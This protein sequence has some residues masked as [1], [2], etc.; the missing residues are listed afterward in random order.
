M[1]VLGSL[2]PKRV[3]KYFE[4]I[5]AIPRGSGNMEG[6]AEYCINFAKKHSLKAVKDNANNVI[7]YK[8]ASEGYENADPV[9]LQGHLDI[10]CQKTEDTNIDF[11]KDGLEIYRDGNFVKAKGTTLGADN[12]IAVAMVLAILEDN[13]LPHPAIEAIFTTDEEIGMIGAG[14]LD[15]S[16]IS[17]KKMINLDAEEDD[18]VTVSCAGGSDFEVNIP[19]ESEINKGT[20]IAITLGGL[21]GGHSGVEI[22]SGR[23]NSNILAGRF[24]NHMQNITNFGIISI[25]GGDKANAIPNCTV[26]KLC[27]DNPESFEETAK[28]YLEIIKNEISAREPNFSFK[29]DVSP[30]KDCLVINPDL[31]EKIISA[32]VSAPN[33]V[34]EMSAEIEGLVETSINLGIL[35]T[36]EN[37]VV[38]HF[39]LRSNKSSALYALEEKLTAFFKSVPC[40]INTFGHYPPWEFKSDSVLRE[41]YKETYTELFDTEPKVEA[42]HAGLECGLFSS[43]IE[44]LDCIAI[45]PQ[46]FDV[47]TVNEKLSISSVERIFN[48]LLK[49]LEKSR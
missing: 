37:E 14:K 26:I 39:A 40:K 43:H 31:T 45:G 30:N 36:N 35:E 4:E 2:E 21:K 32:L 3:F 7:I 12:G 27:T 23:V 38:M 5:S 9:I 48:L 49:I 19:L 17:A 46:L 47:H 11:L 33:G 29:T 28:G 34:M 16:L 24:L 8:N 1:S 10:V 20:E 22:N 13:S 6:I 41:L 15:F 25:N 42:I 18:T 44:G